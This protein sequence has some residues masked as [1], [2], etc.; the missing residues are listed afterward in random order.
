MCGARYHQ[1]PFHIINFFA[2]ITT[3]GQQLNLQPNW[4][5]V[6]C[7]PLW[8]LELD[9]SLESLAVTLESLFFSSFPKDKLT[10]PKNQSKISLFES[11][12]FYSPCPTW[13]T[14]GPRLPSKIQNSARAPLLVA[15]SIPGGHLACAYNLPSSLSRTNVT[16]WNLGAMHHSC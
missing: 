12:G 8:S 6:E 7:L 10:G 9:S 2:S 13:I 14:Q 4:S 5:H 11:W 1:T 3:G 16:T 15:A